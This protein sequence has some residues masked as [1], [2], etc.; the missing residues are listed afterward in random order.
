MKKKWILMGGAI[1]ISGAIMLTTGFTALAST[2][3][4]DDY[5]S[6]LKQTRALESV[7]IQGEAVLKDNGNVLNMATGSLKTNLKGEETSGTVKVTGGSAEQSV[8][9]YTLP[10]GQAWKAGNS[11]TYYVKQDKPEQGDKETSDKEENSSWMSQQAETVIDALVG[12][13]KNEIS[14]NRQSDGSKQISLQ[15]DSAQIPA[16]I[17]ALAPLAFKQLSGEKEKADEKDQAAEPRDPKKL[18]DKNLLNFKDAALTQD[19]QI[20]S[21]SLNAD[22]NPSNQIERQQASVTFIGKDSAGA[23][24]TLS[25]NLDVQLSAFNQTT[26][27]SIDLTGK[28]VQQIK[29]EHRDHGWK[30]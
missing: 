7:T 12:Q 15:L 6:A 27:D 28:Q 25:A 26:P 9:L 29:D 18:F 8:S 1:G 22:I 5:K 17:Q 19:I 30:D 3:G 20:Q 23:S 10:E 13:L 24:H 16:V 14:V 11:D 2:S 4:Y 21:I